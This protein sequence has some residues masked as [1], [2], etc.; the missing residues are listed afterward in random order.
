MAR[1]RYWLQEHRGDTESYQISID[2]HVY[3]LVQVAI[4]RCVCPVKFVQE[5]IKTSKCIENAG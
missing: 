2:Y 1:S 3:H 4:L 5:G